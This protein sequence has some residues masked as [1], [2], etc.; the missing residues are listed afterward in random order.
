MFSVTPFFIQ[1]RRKCSK[2]IYSSEHMLWRL[3]W[4]FSGNIAP[5]SLEPQADRWNSWIVSRVERIWTISRKR[6][7]M[8][9][10]RI[11]RA[12]CKLPCDVLHN[13]LCE[14]YG[15]WWISCLKSN[16]IVFIE[17]NVWFSI[18]KLKYVYV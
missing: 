1:T 4:L 10:L 16:F 17:V 12:N 11:H 7:S 13:F 5:S 8:S 9:Y 3:K 14:L 18:W 2:T 6:I 15:K